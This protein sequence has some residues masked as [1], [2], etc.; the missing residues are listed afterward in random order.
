MRTSFLLLAGAVVLY[1]VVVAPMAAV[2]EEWRPIPKVDDPL[3]Q[4]LGRCAVD[5]QNKVTNCRLRFVKVLGGKVMGDTKYMLA[6]DA[7][8]L[9]GSHKTYEAE[10]LKQSS[11]G[12]NTCKLVSFSPN[13]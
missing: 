11:A 6:I 3:V 1:A 2:G 4:G 9:D 10:V 7:L 12:K 5:E 8:R 13:C